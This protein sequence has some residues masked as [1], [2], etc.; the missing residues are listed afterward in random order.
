MVIIVILLLGAGWFNINF[1]VRPE[2]A[3]SSLRSFGVVVVG[4]VDVGLL[5]AMVVPV[6]WP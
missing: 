3:G 4:V 5:L 1:G 2:G 6:G